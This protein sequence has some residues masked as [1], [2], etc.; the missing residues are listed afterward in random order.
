MLCDE[1]HCELETNNEPTYIEP[2]ASSEATACQYGRDIND[3]DLTFPL[4][5]RATDDANAVF[6]E[7]AV[8]QLMWLSTKTR[9]VR[10][11]GRGQDQNQAN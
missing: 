7:T 10:Q 2:V 11:I 8:G 5:N 3:P 9:G 1:A 6:N 4:D